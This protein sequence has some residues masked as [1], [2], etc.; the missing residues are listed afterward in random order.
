MLLRAM[1]PCKGS[2]QNALYDCFPL[3]ASWRKKCF[4]SFSQKEQDLPQKKEKNEKNGKGCR[5]TTHH[6]KKRRSKKSKNVIE[7]RKNPVKSRL[8][9]KKKGAKVGAKVGAKIRG[10]LKSCTFFKKKTKKN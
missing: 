1:I 10:F 8:S 9:E 6:L 3:L 4:G 7:S 2:N 5:T